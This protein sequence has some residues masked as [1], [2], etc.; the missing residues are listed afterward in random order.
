MY[1]SRENHKN[2]AW[3]ARHAILYTLWECVHP[4]HRVEVMH[5]APLIHNV[6]RIETLLQVFE[7]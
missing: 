2:S 3:V 6:K 1:R 4:L 7:E 5:H